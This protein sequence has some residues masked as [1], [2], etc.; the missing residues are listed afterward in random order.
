[1]Q[2]CR[3]FCGAIRLL[4]ARGRLPWALAGALRRVGR[5]AAAQAG[6]RANI[7]LMFQA[8]VTRLHS[9]RAL[10]SPRIEN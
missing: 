3:S 9:P 6:L 1:L 5:T 8:M 10:S 4:R 7:R 2:P